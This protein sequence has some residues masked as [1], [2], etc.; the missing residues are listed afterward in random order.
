MRGKRERREV[1]PC[2]RRYESSEGMEIWVGRS[3]AENDE[4]TFKEAGQNDFWFHVAATSG[5]HVVVP[6]PDNLTRLPRTTLREAAALA[7][8]HS[9][10]REG[11]KVAVNYTRRRMVRKERGTPAGQVVLQR[12]ETV[13][14]SPRERPPDPPDDPAAED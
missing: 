5:S 14:V 11:G 6:N 4:L 7:A 12:Y 3:A 8:Y 9:K 2:Y 10:S 1:R 13:R